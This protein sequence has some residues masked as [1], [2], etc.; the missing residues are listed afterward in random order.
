MSRLLDAKFWFD[1]IT[2][3]SKIAK[4][5]QLFDTSFPHNTKIRTQSCL[6]TL[7]NLNQVLLKVQQNKYKTYNTLL[8]SLQIQFDFEFG[9]R[10]Q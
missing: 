6:L 10:G 9:Q 3:L 1:L 5:A 2:L 7:Y 8:K 4:I